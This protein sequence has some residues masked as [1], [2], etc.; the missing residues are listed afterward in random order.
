MLL[1]F[2]SISV[3]QTHADDLCVCGVRVRDML[4]FFFRTICFVAKNSYQLE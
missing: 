1:F 3:P 2:C 4:L